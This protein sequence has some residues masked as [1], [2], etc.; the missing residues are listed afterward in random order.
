MME[1]PQQVAKLEIRAAAVYGIKMRR[2]NWMLLLVVVFRR[3]H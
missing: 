1:I 2:W 3:I